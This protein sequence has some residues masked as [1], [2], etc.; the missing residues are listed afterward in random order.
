ME[1]FRIRVL[2]NRVIE[3]VKKG[4]NE[5]YLSNPVY[6]FCIDEKCFENDFFRFYSELTFEDVLNAKQLC[7]K[8][9]K[10]EIS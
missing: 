4:K 10:T 5:D 9:F 8:K 3:F 2:E 6:Y 7:L 1:K